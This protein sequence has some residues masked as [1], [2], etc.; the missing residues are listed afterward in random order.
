M[1]STLATL[2]D[3]VHVSGQKK[4]VGSPTEKVDMKVARGRQ[5]AGRSH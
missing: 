4:I 3:T 5:K 1:K 2:A